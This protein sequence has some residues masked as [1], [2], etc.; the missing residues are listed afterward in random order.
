[1]KTT[2]EIMKVISDVIDL[3]DFAAGLDINLEATV[4]PTRIIVKDQKLCQ[5]IAA[6]TWYAEANGI[7]NATRL[8]EVVPKVQDWIMEVMP[9]RVKTIADPAMFNAN[10][11]RH[12][13]PSPDL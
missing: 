2:R 1:M 7:R 9:Y 12:V 10:T 13:T 5:D 4:S 3:V 8:D 6:W 11:S